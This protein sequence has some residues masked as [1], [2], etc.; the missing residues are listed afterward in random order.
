MGR[1]VLTALMTVG[2]ILAWWLVVFLLAGCAA[3]QGLMAAVNVVTG[4][5][6]AVELW[7]QRQAVARVEALMAPPCCQEARPTETP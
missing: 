5:L 3:A 6:G 1:D 7:A 2:G 4:G